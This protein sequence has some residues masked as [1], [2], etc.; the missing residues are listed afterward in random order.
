MDTS[1]P[2]I[3][4]D[5]DGVCNRCTNFLML[6]DA[7][8]LRPEQREP[9]LRELVA[10]IKAE[11]KHKD[12][13]CIIGV[14]GG[15][16]STYTAYIVKNL[17]LRPLA[18]HLDNG[19][20]AELAVA[21]IEK[22]LKTLGIDLYTC[23]LDWD[24]FRELQLAF[25]KSSTPDSEAPTDHA[26]NAIL[27]HKANE[28]GVR[29]ILMGN[30]LATEGLRVTSW[31]MGQMDWKY[32]RSLNRIFG[33]GRL[34]TF[35]HYT[36]W[37]DAWLRWVKKQKSINIL[38]Y[39]DYHKEQALRLLEEKL[40]YVRYK[41]KHHESVYT[42]FYQSYIL[43]R[44]FGFD[45]RRAHLAALVMSEQIT[46]DQAL[47][48]MTKEIAPEEQMRDDKVFVAKK[49]GLTE[50]QFDDI[51]ALPKKSFW[52]YPSYEKMWIVQ[53]RR[54]LVNWNLERKAAKRLVES[55]TVGAKPAAARA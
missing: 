19:W 33:T 16:D 1:D 46:R 45:K 36:I 29:Y 4:F 3:E 50:K 21:N 7:L 40:G 6:K 48:E 41:G 53:L 37:E 12:Y 38:N 52:D 25:L 14:S 10:Q 2:A 30:N 44:K 17:G 5:A 24:E 42:R 9:A 49:L 31:T 28:L 11:G 27:K 26:I 55:G 47:H 23:V 13:D 39:V 54:K 8:L 22:C 51:M 32:I 34:K 15:V 35:P 18:V 43:P 20:D